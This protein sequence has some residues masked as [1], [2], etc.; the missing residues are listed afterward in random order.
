MA[1]QSLTGF[2]LAAGF[3]LA[4]GFDVLVGANR[5]RFGGGSAT[6]WSA[7]ADAPPDAPGSGDRRRRRQWRLPLHHLAERLELVQVD[8]PVAVGPRSVSP[9]YIN[10]LHALPDRTP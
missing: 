9:M 6:S 7:A 4:T 8:L 2:F 10:A 3:F 1:G 5:G